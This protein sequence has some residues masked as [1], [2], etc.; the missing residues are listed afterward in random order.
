[1]RIRIPS[2]RSRLQVERLENRELLS[3]A[4]VWSGYAGNAQHTAL[5]SV[6][7]QSLDA[8][9]WST[10]VDL[11]P[12]GF[13]GIHY[14]SPMV[15][16]ANTVLVPVKTTS[17]GGFQVEAHSG[18][19][20]SLL[21]TQTTNYTVPSARWTPSFGP[22]LTPS[23]RLYYQEIGGLV[24][25]CDNPDTAGA[26]QTGQFCFYGMSNYNQ[27]PTDYNAHVQICTPLT[28]DASGNIYFGYVVTGS[29]PL[30]LKSGIVRIDP[31]GN[32]T[33]VTVTS[34]AGDSNITSVQYNSA[35]ALSNDGTSAYVGVTAGGG[36]GYLLQL[37]S[38]TLATLAKVKPI[39]PHT[40]NPASLLNISTASP[41]VG[42]DGDVFFG[43]FENPCCSNNDRGWMMHYSGDLSQTKTPGAFGWDDTA[44]IVPTTMVPGYTTSSPYLIFTK[45]N[46]YVGIGTG[47]GEN[48]VAI[49]DPDV[50]MTDPITGATIM[51]EVETILGPTPSPEGGVDEWCINSG[52]V[53]PAT[54]SVLVNSEDGHLY[55]WCLDENVLMQAT[56]LANPTS[57]AY[58]PTIIG[59]D[60]TVYAINDAV[61]DAVG[62]TATISG[63]IYNDLNG[64]GTQDGGEP[65]LSGQSV[66]LLDS[67][68]N[69]LAT[70]TTD[71]NGN[72]AFHELGAG[73]YA[74]QDVTPAGWLQTTP[75]PSVTLSATQQV[76]GISV[77]VFQRVSLGGAVYNDLND[78]HVRDSGEPGLANVI[79]QLNGAA[80]AT[81]DA[82]GNYAITGVGPGTYSIS[83]IIPAAYVETSPTGGV[84][85]VTTSSGN[86]VTNANFANAVPTLTLDNGQT[87]YSENGKGW[88][89]LNQGWNGTSRT[90]AGDNTNKLY[91]SWTFTQKGGIPSGKYEFFVTYV[92]AAG[93]DLTA[94]YLIYDG[95]TKRGKASV[96]Q[97]ASPGDALYQGL[98]WKSLGSFNVVHGRA[99]VQLRVDPNGSVD[100][101]GVLII[102]AGAAA[103]PQGLPVMADI[104]GT[105]GDDVPGVITDLQMIGVSA[106]TA[107]TDA[108]PVTPAANGGIV[109]LSAA[110]PEST[111]ALALQA[112]AI[113]LVFHNKS[114]A[115]QSD[116]DQSL[117]LAPAF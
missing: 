109:A 113:D 87:G 1:M 115:G 48:K 67:S 50:S 42:P 30:N 78:N 52:V 15:T 40:G 81:T 17:G 77:G 27:D 82:N 5:S 34:A 84:L 20:G 25:Y 47:N 55:R 19:D 28:S 3:G 65:G 83:A 90:H 51:N 9:R 61:L 117:I 2:R 54:D 79:I 107:S 101:D 89:T 57:E 59:A 116:W 21:W 105:P 96:D 85:S 41:M 62:Q 104:S 66:D 11:Q 37:D 114:A 14:G 10:P 99:V 13:L 68:G 97:T 72:Y 36:Y 110:L 60:G 108:A 6:A 38:T 31:S 63:Q 88:Q 112:Q 103:T 33:A 100:A 46:N 23:N 70:T 58:T 26:T 94:S 102:P 29:T 4:P 53:D 106:P 86:N 91:A 44:S 80:A 76:S 39:D 32:A 74:I 98:G 24:D 75:N 95:N 64:N 7:S 49:L 93:R 69:V 18:L 16:A 12:P 111:S 43:V 22:T 8:V 45:Y 56:F 35:P 73:A 92:P 71:S